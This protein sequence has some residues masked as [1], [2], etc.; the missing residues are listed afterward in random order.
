MEFNQIIN[1]SVLTTLF[2]FELVDGGFRACPGNTGSTI[3]PDRMLFRGGW[4]PENPAESIRTWRE[5]AEKHREQTWE[6]KK[7]GNEAWAYLGSGGSM[8]EVLNY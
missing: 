1:A 7:L 5:R 6:R 4:K 3:L 8:T 2:W